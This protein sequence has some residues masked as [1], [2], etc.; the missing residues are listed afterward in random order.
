MTTAP[1]ALQIGLAVLAAVRS[2]SGSAVAGTNSRETH[3]LQ[4]ANHGLERE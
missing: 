3:L 1:A 4:D 2:L